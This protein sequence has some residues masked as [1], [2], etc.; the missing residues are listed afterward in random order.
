MA[1][2]I[3]PRDSSNLTPLL[4][5]AAAASSEDTHANST[6]PT[7][8]A[9]IRAYADVSLESLIKQLKDKEKLILTQEALIEM[10]RANNTRLNH[11]IKEMETQ[12]AASRES[13][14]QAE[15]ALAQLQNEIQRLR[16]LGGP[17]PSAP[18]NSNKLYRLCHLFYR[19]RELISATITLGGSILCCVFIPYSVPIA[20]ATGGSILLFNYVAS[21]FSKP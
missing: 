15:D 3:G 10:V 20:M 6:S 14:V 5:A 16:L 18:R 2:P 4:S 19:H 7:F 17:A 11:E 9:P 12:R 8:D 13:C 1:S 21:F